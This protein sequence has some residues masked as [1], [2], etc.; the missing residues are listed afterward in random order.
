LPVDRLTDDTQCTGHSK[1]TGERCTREIKKADRERG[2]T[3]CYYH[4]SPAPQV[5][6]A[7]VKR[8]E[9]KRARAWLERQGFDKVE[10]P[11]EALAELAGEVVAVKDYFREQIDK[12]RYE[13]RAG[14]QLRAEVALYE[15]ALDR[16]HR[17]LSDITRL[18]IAE[19]KARISEAQ[20]VMILTILSN[21]LGR[22]EL[23]AP[24]RALAMSIVQEELMAAGEE[25]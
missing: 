5:Q 22:L 3:V 4:G 14:E 16:C 23:S 21:T 2:I 18:G 20:A 25:D 11:V 19:R 7:G 8:Y 13:H 10:D 6:F 12:L 9:E 24:K 15:R 17:V 1:E